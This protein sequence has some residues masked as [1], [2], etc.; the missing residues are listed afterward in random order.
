[1]GPPT[2]PSLSSQQ[3]LVDLGMAYSI[4]NTKNEQ[5]GGTMEPCLWVLISMWVLRRNLGAVS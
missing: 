1:M 5:A 2:L 3:G 4:Q